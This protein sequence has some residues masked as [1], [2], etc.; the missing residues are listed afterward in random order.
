MK[1]TDIVLKDMQWHLILIFLIMLLLSIPRQP[2]SP[3]A[4]EIKAEFLIE[5]SW[6][7]ES[8][9]D[10]DLWFRAPGGEKVWFSS[11]QVSIYSLERD[12]L[13][14]RSDLVDDPE[15]GG[16]KVVKI[17]REILTMR[18]SVAGEY[19]V[20]LHVYSWKDK[21]PIDAVVRVIKLNPFS[22]VVERSV[23]LS[24]LGQEVAGAAFR[25]DA[26]GNVVHLSYELIPIT[27]G[28]Q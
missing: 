22:V 19:R 21:A 11:R 9:S 13:G 4:V 25:V 17:N 28:S 6:P 2:V 16:V 23:P 10:I 24:M 1:T 20:N 12:D 5:V 26:N 7:V 15:T 14:C 18:G 8:C 3:P 27:R